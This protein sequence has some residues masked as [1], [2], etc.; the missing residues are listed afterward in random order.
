[1]AALTGLTSKVGPIIFSMASGLPM[2]ITEQQWVLVAR[3]SG[4]QMAGRTGLAKRVGPRALSIV[5]RLPM[6]IMEQLSVTKAQ[7]LAPRTEETL[8]LASPAVPLT[9]LWAY[10]LQMPI[11]EQQLGELESSSEQPM[12]EIAGFRRQAEQRMTSVT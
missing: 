4:Q 11:Q 6:Q 10:S 9:Q 5:S 12:A 7:S 3:S 2:Q 8:G 1:M